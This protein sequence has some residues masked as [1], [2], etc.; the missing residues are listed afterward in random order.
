MMAEA[1]LLATIA[2]TFPDEIY[3]FL[4]S[5]KDIALKRKTISKMCDSFRISQDTKEKFKQLR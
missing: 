4:S 2:I 1:W 5:T 3:Q